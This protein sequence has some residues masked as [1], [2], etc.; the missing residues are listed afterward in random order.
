MNRLAGIV[1]AVLGLIVIVLTVLKVVPGMWGTG[2]L[3]ILVGVI[4]IGLSFVS[5]PE[6]DGTP[7]MSTAATIGNIFV[8]PGEVFQNLRRHPRWLAVLIIAAIVSSTYS[9]LF[10]QR[11]TPERVV[12]FMTDKTVQMPMI[13]NNPEAVK[14]VEQG[15]P[16]AI[17]DAQN[18]VLIAASFLNDFLGK[19]FLT[20]LLSAIFFLFILALGGKA[21]YW[22]AFAAVAYA[23]FPVAVIRNI[24]GAVILYLKDPVD[25]HPVLGQSGGVLQDS[26]AFLIVPGE[27]PVLYVILGSFSLL[28]FYW[29]FL[30]SSG[31]KNAGE[32][33]SSTT[34]WTATLVIFI[35]GILL[36][37]GWV[38]MFPGFMS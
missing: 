30:N 35:I 6:E 3:L 5:G 28:S 10:M 29:I 2:L 12:N 8:S 15:R 7:R 26:L 31:L 38:A 23:W 27:H 32:K 36:F 18:P 13:A 22:Q 20:A 19:V 4:A 21:N 34:A 17:A 25:I 24:L 11:L 14:N 1:S 9:V 33:V 16:Q 37:S